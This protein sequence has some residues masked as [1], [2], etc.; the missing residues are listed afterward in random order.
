MYMDL[1]KFFTGCND[2]RFF[3]CDVFGPALLPLDRGGRPLSR[4]GGD[5]G[6]LGD[7]PREGPLAGVEDA[8]VRGHFALGERPLRTYKN[9]E[10][11]YC[12]LRGC[13]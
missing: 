13:Q 10:Q 6:D 2:V 1:K 11:S 9:Y 7:L 8:V 3:L 4:G 5:H 12:R